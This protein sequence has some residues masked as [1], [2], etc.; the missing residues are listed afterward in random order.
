MSDY[1]FYVVKKCEI[2][3]KMLIEFAYF[4]G[5]PEV[6]RIYLHFYGDTQDEWT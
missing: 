3:V 5:I 1:V 2:Y 6:M 4:H